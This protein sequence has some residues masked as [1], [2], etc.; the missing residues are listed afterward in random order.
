[1][2]DQPLWRRFL[3]WP[4]TRQGWWSAGFLVGILVFFGAFQALVA[5][6]QRGGET[7]F[8]NPWLAVAILAAAGSAI[9]GGVMAGIAIFRKGERSFFSF[10]ALLLGILVAI[11]MIGEIA[12][13]H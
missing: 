2:S 6:G 11:F 10:V 7:F 13:P 8:S 3:N 12:L 1:V 5:S 4:G 9:A